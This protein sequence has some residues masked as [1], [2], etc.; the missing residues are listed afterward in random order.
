MMY[1]LSIYQRLYL[2]PLVIF[3]AF[4]LL[5]HL[6]FIYKFFSFFIYKHFIRLPDGGFVFKICTLS[7]STVL[8]RKHSILHENL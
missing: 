4:L 3:Q 7:F 2:F 1:S 6:Y 5:P 8:D